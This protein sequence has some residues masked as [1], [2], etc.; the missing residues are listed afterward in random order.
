MSIEI[1]DAL[2]AYG[3]SLLRN[4]IAS[5]AVLGGEA[6]TGKVPEADKEKLANESDSECTTT[7]RSSNF[8]LMVLPARHCSC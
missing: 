7:D 6:A 8:M 3:N 5:S 4:G 2:E 1:V